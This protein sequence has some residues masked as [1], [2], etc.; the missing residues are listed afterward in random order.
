[1]ALDLSSLTLVTVLILAVST[2][3]LAAHWVAN[4][5][6]AGLGR[7]AVGMGMATAGVVIFMMAAGPSKPLGILLGDLLILMGHL[8]FWLGIADYW[9]ERSRRLTYLAGFIMVFAIIILVNNVM[10]GGTPENRAALYSFFV[11]VFS[12]GAALSVVQALGGRVGLYK[13]IIKRKTIGTSTI[14]GVFFAHAA[15]NVYRGIVLQSM[16][17]PGAGGDQSALAS[18]TQIEGTLF[19]LALTV[20]MIV[21]TAE[22][23]QADLR[24]QAM[25]DPLTHALNR[26]AFM[27]VIKTVL[28]RSRRLSEP[29]SLIMMDIDKFKRINLKHGHLVGDA[30]LRQFADGVME[31]RRA[32]DVFCRFGGE[33]FVLLLP[34]T[35]EEGAELVAHRVRDAVTGYPFQY[36]KKDISLTVSFGVTTA[37]GDDLLPDSILD[38]A[39]KAL[40]EAQKEGRN[41]IEVSGSGSVKP[42]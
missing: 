15:F 12:T 31:G 13:G 20:S 19:A 35:S 25:M 33:E 5:S 28:A 6:F 32:Q 11:A 8:W 41:Q 34:G 26:R 2:F 4:F 36:G 14:A 23:V 18:I 24:I 10:Q 17:A 30:I 29:V 21:S 40:R 22:R 3:V 16:T 38:A 37:R 1:M 7:I 9:K 42:G 27:T 39:Y